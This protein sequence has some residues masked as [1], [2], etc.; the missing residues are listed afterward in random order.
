[1]INKDY[2]KKFQDFMDNGIYH[3]ALDV[4]VEHLPEKVREAAISVYDWR[5]NDKIYHAALDVAVEHLPE[6]VDE[7]AI[8][9]YESWMKRNAYGNALEVATNHLPELI[10]TTAV[11]AMKQGLEDYTNLIMRNN[12]EDKGGQGRAN[13]II[14]PLIKNQLIDRAK[15][16]LNPDNMI[17]YN[18]ENGMETFQL[19]VFS[20]ISKIEMSAEKKWK[21][22]E[23]FNLEEKLANAITNEDYRLAG[24]IKNN[25]D[26]LSL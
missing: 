8:I 20:E 5:M 23:K 14:A 15:A 1:M 9:T 18:S 12:P 4:A 11:S 13:L 26:S 16:Y 2:I 10:N 25:L 24:S 21:N 7:T 3:A 22:P 19:D 17:N 6:M